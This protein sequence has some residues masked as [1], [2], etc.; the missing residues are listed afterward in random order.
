MD[1]TISLQLHRRISICLQLFWAALILCGSFSM[2]QVLIRTW[3]SRTTSSMF[4]EKAEHRLVF[5]KNVIVYEMTLKTYA[6][7]IIR[8]DRACWTSCIHRA[9]S[10]LPT[11]CSRW[12]RWLH[13]LC[14]CR[15][16][17]RW[18]RRR[19]IG[20]GQTSFPSPSL[21]AW[22]YIKMFRDIPLRV[23]CYQFYVYLKL[24]LAC[25]GLTRLCQSVESPFPKYIL[26][27]EQLESE[28]CWGWRERGFASD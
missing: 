25:D 23:L 1:A 21:N 15:N 11:Q 17:P 28:G 7:A 24:L 4:I 13:S 9:C 27:I 26:L 10:N 5:P 3:P 2:Q 20:N 12:T 19:W 22:G 8:S 18:A 14:I 16:A 6:G